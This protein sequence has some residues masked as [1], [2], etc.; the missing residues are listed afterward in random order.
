MQLLSAALAGVFCFCAP[1]SI[2]DVGNSF[3]RSAVSVDE[4]ISVRE[5]IEANGVPLL[6]NVTP[7]S[8]FMLPSYPCSVSESFREL[9]AAHKDTIPSEVTCMAEQYQVL[10]GMCHIIVS[11]LQDLELDLDLIGGLFASRQ[12]LM[13]NRSRRSLLRVGHEFLQDLGFLFSQFRS[14]CDTYEWCFQRFGLIY[15]WYEYYIKV[16]FLQSS[17][18]ARATHEVAESLHGDSVS[19]ADGPVYRLSPVLVYGAGHAGDVVGRLLGLQNDRHVPLGSTEAAHS[20]AI[21]VEIGVFRGDSAVRV[22]QS[23]QVS[24]MHLVDMWAGD[25]VPVFNRSADSYVFLEA[26]GRFL[27]MPYVQ[28]PHWAD[29]AYRR[30][31]IDLG[32]QAGGRVFIHRVSGGE[33]ANAI[34][35]ESIDVVFIDADH[36]AYSVATD[37]LTWWPKVK[38]GGILAGH[39]FHF[40]EPGVPYAVHAFFRYPAEVFLDDA[41][42]WWVR[43]PEDPDLAYQIVPTLAAARTQSPQVT[44][45]Q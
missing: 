5:I 12:C 38:L 41:Y 36:E 7:P 40:S 8:G 25:D 1:A 33:A 34:D 19:H 43:K 27:E 10:R 14:S 20:K 30:Q 16:L 6:F 29:L 9:F 42:V 4:D 17:S 22:W 15:R 21:Y 31:I 13:I 11:D 39:D 32:R 35:D 24:T 3:G 2:D 18:T 45:L 28:V 37:L 26:L 23:G 44:A